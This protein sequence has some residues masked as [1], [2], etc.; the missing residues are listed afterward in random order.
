MASSMGLMM[1]QEPV[2]AMAP[3]WGAGAEDATTFY[4]TPQMDVEVISRSFFRSSLGC[5]FVAVSDTQL[6]EAVR[7]PSSD[8]E[9]RQLVAAVT[10][11]IDFYEATSAVLIADFEGE[12][13]GY[14]GELITG[15]FVPTSSVEPGSLRKLATNQPVHENQGLLIDM[16]GS[17]GIELVR[18][19]MESR[20]ITK[21]IWGADSDISSLRFQAFP[22]EV[23]VQPHGVVDVQLAFSSP[24]WRLGL[25]RALET[26]SRNGQSEITS[27]LPDK[28]GLDF[29]TPHSKNR[30][31]LVL[32][33]GELE[34]RYAADD[35]HRIEA[36]L[37]G[38]TPET[39]AYLQAKAVSD[40]V[41]ANLAADPAGFRKL[42]TDLDWFQTL[43][44]HKRDKR[45]VEITRHVMSVRARRLQLEPAQEQY[46]D[47]ALVSVE[48]TLRDAGI[49]IPADLSFNEG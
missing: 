31:A 7:P 2:A 39:G 20:A 35:L 43:V 22:R 29:D 34:A 8:A 40:Q 10:R 21:L 4:D 13:L 49:V 14:G 46:M 30:R 27:A 18:R 36:V 42:Q 15:A 11:I 5:P 12:M 32:P 28:K 19:I 26:V 44:G 23:G 45:A 33:L 38:S 37:R 3:Q 16:R 24:T 25:A 1:G 48:Q 9:S 17:S 47:Q 6:V 41:A